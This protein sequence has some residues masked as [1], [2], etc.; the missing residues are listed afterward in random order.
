MIAWS[1]ALPAV[2]QDYD[3][4]PSGRSLYALA[5]LRLTLSDGER[6]WLDGG[7]GKSRFGGGADRDAAA[8]ARAVEGDLVWQPHLGWALDATI[9]ASA[10]QGQDQPV[11][12]SEA[13]LHYRHA[14]IGEVR[15]GARLGY[16]WPPISL[17]HSGPAW[18]VTETITPS[19]INSWIGEEVKVAGAE[20]SASAP[21]G[22]GRLTATAA[23]FGLDDTAGTLLSFRGWALH[24]EKATA[25]SL[26]P[27]PPLDDFMEYAQ[28]P[29]T[30]PA[31]EIDN[32]PGFY[33]K[34][35]WASHLMKLQ[36]FYYDN[37]GDP[38]AVRPTLQWGWRTRFGQIAAQLKPDAKTTITSQAMIGST[39]MGF[40]QP[41]LIW[42]DTQFR[43]AFLL[44]TRRIGGHSSVSARAEAFGTRGRGSVLGAATDEDGWAATLA[45]RHAI[46]DHV[47]VLG[48]Q[49][50][51]DSTRDERARVVLAPHQ[52]QTI[53][54]V[55]ARVTL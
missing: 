48:E 51:V 11:D 37:R 35:G 40:P 44:A 18:S 36:A 17:E 52:A 41:T 10:Q 21:L 49:L 14:P 25:F 55:S 50:H 33:A 3:E 23:V 26:Q 46:D 38:E 2:A 8:R 4:N 19:A 34:L 5:D 6:S 45:G 28:A 12:L 29:R 32:R 9:A 24:D 53:A 27:L 31:L 42:V 1:V 15:V 54:Q 13:Y 39:R 7:F 20:A 47:T 30:R 16:F 22:G 43:S